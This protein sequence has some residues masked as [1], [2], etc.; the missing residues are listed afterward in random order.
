MKEMKAAEFKAKCLRV[1]AE[2]EATGEEVV[3]TRRGK[4]IARLLPAIPVPAPRVGFGAGAHFKVA[5]D[6][7]IVAPLEDEWEGDERNLV[8]ASE[9]ADAGE[10]RG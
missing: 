7:D 8:A 5:Y 10:R 4:P 1:M 3:I 6:G 9:P 2:V